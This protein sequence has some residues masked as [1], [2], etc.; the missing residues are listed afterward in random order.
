LLTI[1][2]FIINNKKEN[3]IWLL[4]TNIAIL[5][6]DIINLIKKSNLIKEVDRVTNDGLSLQ[7]IDPFRATYTKESYIC[8]LNLNNKVSPKVLFNLLVVGF[9]FGIFGFISSCIGLYLEY[10]DNY[11]YKT[12][13]L[14]YYANI[15]KVID[16]IVFVIEFSFIIALLSLYFLLIMDIMKVNCINQKMVERLLY[17]YLI[18]LIHGVYLV[19]RK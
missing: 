17:I 7:S 13:H 8:N 1:Y 4:L 9:V 6:L 10:K 14:S 2:N 11:G 19:I 15:L 12:D 5:V 16:I 3:I 18:I